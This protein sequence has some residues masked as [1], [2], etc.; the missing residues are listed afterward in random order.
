MADANHALDAADKQQDIESAEHTGPGRPWKPGES[1]NPA[2]RPKKGEAYAEYLRELLELPMKELK[3][4][5][6]ARN[7]AEMPAKKAMALRQVMDGF[8]NGHPQRLAVAARVR[9]YTYNR[10]DG[11]PTATVDV[12]DPRAERTEGYLETM[13]ANM[14]AA[15]KALEAAEVPPDGTAT[16]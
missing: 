3:R 10:L 8:L 7:M 16:S 9:A 2:G 5:A 11:T 4:L 15:L 1:G 12:H 14:E 6:T 13:A